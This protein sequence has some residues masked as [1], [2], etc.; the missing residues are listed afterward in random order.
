MSLHLSSF[1]SAYIAAPKLPPPS[2]FPI[3]SWSEASL[4]VGHNLATTLP[5]PRENGGWRGYWFVCRRFRGRI[6]TG[7]L[8]ISFAFSGSLSDLIIFI[9]RTSPMR[10][11]RRNETGPLSSV[12]CSSCRQFLCCSKFICCMN[13]CVICNFLPIADD[14]FN[15]STLSSSE[16]SALVQVHGEVGLAFEL[17]PCS[18][19]I[20]H[21]VCLSL[22]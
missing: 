16:S 20:V 21:V 7:K 1:V 8:I 11:W 2:P 14:Y 19:A 13:E 22:T 15:F 12:D 10:Y 3:R 9:F 18:L 4:G 5:L 17:T 6:W